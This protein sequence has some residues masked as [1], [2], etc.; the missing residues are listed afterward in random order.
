MKNLY[1]LLAVAGG[2][3]PYAFF[4]P[5]F[6]AHGLDLAAFAGGLLANGAAAG[7]AVDVVLSSL[8][9]W[10]AIAR[11]WRQG[12]GPHPAVFIALN[13]LVGLSCALPAYLY[14]LEARAAPRPA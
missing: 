7:F 13:L 5:F 10:V 1:L 12:A 14:A 9:F 6:G 8:V 11:R 4:I 3:L 2:V